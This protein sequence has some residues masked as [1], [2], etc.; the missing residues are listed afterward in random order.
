[1]SNE[2]R[3]TMTDDE[4]AASFGISRNDPQP[5]TLMCRLCDTVLP[6]DQIKSCPVGNCRESILCPIHLKNHVHRLWATPEE[7]MSTNMADLIEAAIKK[8]L[9][10]IV[11][12]Y[13][14]QQKEKSRDHSEGD[15]G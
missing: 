2:N 7:S 5:E 11:E 15:D 1:M 10:G 3:E 4:L 14:K 9:P 13:M 8:L 12:E 6:E